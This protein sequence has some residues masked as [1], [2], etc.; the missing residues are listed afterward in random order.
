MRKHYVVYYSVLE[1]TQYRQEHAKA[2]T[3]VGVAEIIAQL[4]KEG[5]TPLR[6]EKVERSKPSAEEQK[7]LEAFLNLAGVPFSSI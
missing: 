7:A 1:G 4:H 5:I 6:W 3:I 2:S